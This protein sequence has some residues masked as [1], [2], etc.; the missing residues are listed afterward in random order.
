MAIELLDLR[1]QWAKIK[2]G[3]SGGPFNRLPARGPNPKGYKDGVSP[4]TREV[5]QSNMSV[6]G[7]VFT[8]KTFSNR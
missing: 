5:Q 3:F 4:M 7:S 8:G 2:A 6:K 1:K